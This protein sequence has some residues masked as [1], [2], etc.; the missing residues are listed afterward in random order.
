MRSVQHLFA[1]RMGG[2]GRYLIRVGDAL[3]QFLNVLIL[4]GKNPNESISG[5][6]WRLRATPGWRQLRI[7]IDFLFSYWQ[8]EHCREAFFNDLLRARQLL[9]C[10]TDK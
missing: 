8:E 1:V 7:V 6:A 2:A 4:F 9:R 5:R 10:Y 3:S